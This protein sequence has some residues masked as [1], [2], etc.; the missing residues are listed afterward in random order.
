MAFAFKTTR[1]CAKTYHGISSQSTS[2]VSLRT[3]GVQSTVYKAVDGDLSDMGL[4]RSLVTILSVLKPTPQY[5]QIWSPVPEAHKL[6]ETIFGS[7]PSGSLL[8]YQLPAASSLVDSDTV[9]ISD[10]PFPPFFSYQL[11]HHHFRALS[12][13]TAAISLTL[14]K[15]Q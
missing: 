13:K 6:S 7:V 5:L 11:W 9:L 10:V 8:S 2:T 4:D 14:S 1:I 12:L 3:E 15:H